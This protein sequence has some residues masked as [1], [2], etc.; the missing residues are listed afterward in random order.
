M[1]RRTFLQPWTSSTTWTNGLIRIST[2]LTTS[3]DPTR[4][5]R[6]TGAPTHL[7]PWAAATLVQPGKWKKRHTLTEGRVCVLLPGKH[8]SQVSH[9]SALAAML[10][11]NQCRCVDVQLESLQT[12]IDPQLHPAV[13]NYSR[14]PRTTIW[15]FCRL[16]HHTRGILKE[17]RSHLWHAEVN[18]SR[19]V[20]LTN[21][22]T[23]AHSKVLTRLPATSKLYTVM[24]L[25][26]IRLQ[27]T[28][29]L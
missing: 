21:A 7:M 2:S 3:T 4:R 24:S 5:T 15:S 16:H 20:P 22:S 29:L 9:I 18:I 8:S 10:T 25:Q 12:K 26:K 19:N 17:Q 14:F 11:E 27:C 23:K 28:R 1:T 6:L 13:E